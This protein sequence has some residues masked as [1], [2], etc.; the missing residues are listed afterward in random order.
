VTDPTI[1]KSYAEALFALGERHHEHAAY[2]DAAET[3]ARLLD[4]DPRIRAFLLSP[5]IEAA[6][7]KAA[8][9]AALGARVPKRFLVYVYVVI[10]KR[11]QRLLPQILRAYRLLLDEHLG[12]VHAQVTLAREP[13]ERLEEEIGAGLGRVLGKRVIPHIR[14]EPGIL[15]GIIVRY[16]DNI[17][18]G[19]LR[20]RL[21]GLRSRMLD[22]GRMAVR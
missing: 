19:S 22:G 10:D 6:E 2:T 4:G 7:K 15:G 8:L 5:R 17:I 21:L 1:A 14:V 13:D 9:G 3:L 18:D 20:R 12:V 11:R 16:A